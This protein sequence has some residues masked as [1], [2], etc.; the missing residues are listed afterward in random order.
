LEKLIEEL[1]SL[2]LNS[3]EA[4]IYVFFAK[5]QSSQKKEIMNQLGIGEQ[6]LRDSLQRL[7]EKGF[8]RI[9]FKDLNIFSIIPLKIVMERLIKEKLREVHEIRGEIRDI[10]DLK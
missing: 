1:R 3:Q 5:N 7:T 8:I 2:G 10:D 9:K 6:E 4:Y